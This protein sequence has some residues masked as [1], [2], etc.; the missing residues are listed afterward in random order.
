MVKSKQAQEKSTMAICFITSTRERQ[1]R[2]LSSK[3]AEDKGTVEI[4]V[5]NKKKRKAE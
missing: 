1:G 2:I 5:Q 3:Q 4:L